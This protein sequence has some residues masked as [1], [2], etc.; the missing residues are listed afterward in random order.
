MK[1]NL[2]KIFFLINIML[3]SLENLVKNLC[4]FW[5]NVKGFVHIHEILKDF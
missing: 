2:G 1:I 3:N 5:R 4:S